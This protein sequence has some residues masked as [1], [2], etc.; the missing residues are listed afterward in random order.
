MSQ[1]SLKIL[2]FTNGTASHRWRLS[3]I[4]ERINH[5]TPHEM[6]VA[7]FDKWSGSTLGADIVIL[8][9][10]TAPKMVEACQQQ[11]AKVIFEADDA[12]ID[13]YGKDRKNLQQ[14]GAGWRENAIKT[15]ELCD[16]LTVTNTYLRDNYARF[17]NKPIHILPNYMDTKWYPQNKLRIDRNTDE[18]RIGW[19]GSKG[20]YEDLRMM[21]PALKNVLEKYPQAKFVYCGFGGMSSDRLV[22]SVGWGEDVFSEIP[23]NRREF[24]IAV[25]ED[26]WPIKHQTL[27]FDIGIAPLIDDPFNH[28]KTNI[29][30]Q[31][32][33]MNET[34]CVASKPVYGEHPFSPSK[35]SITH[36]KNGFIATTQEEWE[37]YLGQLIESAG[38]RKK[39]GKA[40][41]E[42][43]LADWNI[44]RHCNKW[45]ALYE[46]VVTN[47]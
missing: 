11:G 17:T 7:S 1:R 2:A 30:W 33:A 14:M 37:Q 19:F 24:V 31:E 27:D 45:V 18:V 21:V 22:T 40:A 42:K 20:H 4:A 10:L 35:S 6:F 34:P 38:L 15:V 12:F 28:C 46:S 26:L 39:M 13:T 47:P 41:K 16:M 23:R 29:K 9:M 5:L 36:G 32:Y 3:N 44:D 8:E 43:V 25:H